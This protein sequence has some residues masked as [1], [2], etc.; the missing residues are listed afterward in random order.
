MSRSIVDAPNPYRIAE[1]QFASEGSYAS[2][3]SES[4]IFFHPTDVSNELHLLLFARKNW[5]MALYLKPRILKKSGI[6][7][8]CYF[9]S[10]LEYLKGSL[11]VLLVEALALKPKNAFYKAKDASDINRTPL[12]RVNYPSGLTSGQG[13]DRLST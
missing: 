10:S 7:K 5:Q 1:P 6:F 11:C 12:G 4:V 3:L 2:I 13:T 9:T 8:I